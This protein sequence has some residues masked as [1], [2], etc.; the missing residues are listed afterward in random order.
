MWG[1]SNADEMQMIG[2][3]RVP[4]PDLL[5]LAINACTGPKEKALPGIPIVQFT[6]FLCVHALHKSFPNAKEGNDMKSVGLN[7]PEN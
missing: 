1:V 5:N 7:F 2:A 6:F 3:V 4:K